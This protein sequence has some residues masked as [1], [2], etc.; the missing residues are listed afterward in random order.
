MA[1]SPL[2]VPPTSALQNGRAVSSPLKNVSS[3]Q[4]S[5]NGTPLAT[6][7]VPNAT[8]AAQSTSLDL[9]EQLN[10]DE[11]RKYAKGSVPLPH[12]ANVLLASCC[13]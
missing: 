13:G 2:I 11:K 1:V 6:Q 7:V 12:N 10:E 9:A 5:S 8:A 3:A 4:A